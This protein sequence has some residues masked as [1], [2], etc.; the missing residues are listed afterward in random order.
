ME[1]LWLGH[2]LV[3]GQVVFKQEQGVFAQEP[4]EFTGA[5]QRSLGPNLQVSCAEI[6]TTCSRIWQSL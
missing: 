6:Q 5:F 2:A 3:L 1:Y 4:P